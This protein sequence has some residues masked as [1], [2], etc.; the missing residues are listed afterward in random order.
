MQALILIR[1]IFQSFINS[2]FK[3]P[4]ENTEILRSQYFGQSPIETRLNKCEHMPLISNLISV[5]TSISLPSGYSGQELVLYCFL[6]ECF[7]LPPN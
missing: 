7:L 3:S 5:P 4:Y 2:E 1:N 6:G